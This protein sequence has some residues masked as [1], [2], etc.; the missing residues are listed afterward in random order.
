MSLERIYKEYK[1]GAAI[2][3]DTR[4]ITKGC[5]FFAL[6]GPS[7][8]GNSFALTALESGAG[9][10]VVDDPSVT[11]P[12][13]ILVTDVLEFLQD[14]AR[15]HRKTLLIP[16]IGITG[17]NGK[18]TTKELVSRV[19][20]KRYNTYF[21]Q[22]NL[23]NH[24]GVPLTL[25]SITEDHEAAVVEMGANHQKEIELLCSIALPSDVLITNVGKAHLEG[26][27]GFEGVKK[28]KGEMYEYAR[29]H[30]SLVFI[31]A[32]NEHLTEMLGDYHKTFTYGMRNGT[33]VEGQLAEDSEFVSL[34]WK[35]RNG[36][37]HKLHSSLT[38]QYNAE[39]ILAAISV[40]IHFKV[41]PNAI[42]EA[43]ESYK[44]DNQRSQV[45]KTG[46][47][48]VV[49]DAYNANPTSM[50]AAIR[51]FRSHYNEPT[52]VFIGEM[53]ELGDQSEKEHRSI[54]S[55]ITT[56]GFSE[57]ILVGKNFC[58]VNDNRYKC[59]ENSEAAKEYILSRKFTGFNILVKGSRGSKMEVAAQGLT[60]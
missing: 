55:L 1:A 17:S 45:L 29:K 30:H 42:N 47:N 38:G 24:I 10:A 36:E 20:A 32:A 41:E 21:T 58:S 9:F 23:N 39:N 3:T 8:N 50:E 14:L 49:M 35:N 37:W 27:G 28:G 4:K 16:V 52:A 57:V 31:N 46:N 59:F 19:L 5:I 60:Q 13:A 7:F 54:L 12:N 44:P 40:G 15:H 18:T 6:K 56:L 33:D 34:R 2:C 22:G 51:N 25:L 43:I 26:F 53:L 11:H 48:T